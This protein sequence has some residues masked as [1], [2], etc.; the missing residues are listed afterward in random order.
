[1]NKLD[2]LKK[3]TTIVSDS[4]EFEEIKKYLPT[5]AT[6]NPSLILAASTKPEYQFLIEEA[7]QW[8][9]K[10]EKRKGEPRKTLAEKFFIICGLEIQKI[11][12]GG[13]SEEGDPRLSFNVQ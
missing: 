5:D 6:T 7:I 3:M 10:N 8:G 13:A 9:K 2:Q 1:M 4:G 12:P 11:I